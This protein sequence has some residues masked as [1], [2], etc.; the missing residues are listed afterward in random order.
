MNSSRLGSAENLSLVDD[1]LTSEAA[2]AHRIVKELPANSIVMA[3]SAFGIYSVAHHATLAG[4]DFLFRLTRSRFKALRRRAD[5]I[6]E[7]A[8]HKTYHLFWTPSAKD[9]KSTPDLPQDAS[10]EVALHE[11]EINSG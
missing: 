8:L 9:R 7:G 5:L 10:I 4:H 2:Q 1:F 3:D 11:V 6:D